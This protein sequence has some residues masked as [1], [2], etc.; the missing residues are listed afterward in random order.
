[1]KKKIFSIILVTCISALLL[2]GNI[3][4]FALDEYTYTDSFKLSKVSQASSGIT[5]NVSKYNGQAKLY[6]QHWKGCTFPTYSDTARTQIKSSSGWTSTK[7]SVNIY[8]GPVADGPC[9]KASDSTLVDIDAGY[10]R[11]VKRTKHTVTLTNVTGKVIY[12]VDGTP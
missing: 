3:Y 11:T 2:V 6:F 9:A 1:M 10:G 5:R 12:K 4:A 7:C 8:D